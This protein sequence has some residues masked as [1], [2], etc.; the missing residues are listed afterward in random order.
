[1]VGIYAKNNHDKNMHASLLNDNFELFVANPVTWLD[2]FFIS[3]AN[4]ISSVSVD[5]VND[6]ENWR[7]VTTADGTNMSLENCPEG[8]T[9]N[10]NLIRQIYPFFSD[11]A[12]ADVLVQK[13]IIHLLQLKAT[14][15]I[16][17]VDG[18]NYKFFIFNAI[19]DNYICQVNTSISENAS[20]ETRSRQL[21]FASLNNFF[22]EIPGKLINPFLVSHQKLIQKQP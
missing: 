11:L 19:N 7:L 16:T 17:D 6:D 5:F 13:D 9:V 12:I 14:I 15:A 2:P 22:Y 18:I 1:P 4:Q 21:K 3:F 10:M 20:D 8:F